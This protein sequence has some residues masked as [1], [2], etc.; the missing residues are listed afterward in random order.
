M[1]RPRLAAHLAAVLG[2]EAG[3]LADPDSIGTVHGLGTFGPLA[4]EPYLAKQ[5]IEADPGERDGIDERQP[6]EGDPDGAPFHHHPQ[7]D[8]RHYHGVKQQQQPAEEAGKQ[9]LDVVFQTVEQ[10]DSLVQ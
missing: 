1:Q 3:Q 4:T 7:R 2:E 5:H 10:G 9:Q 6:G 8:P